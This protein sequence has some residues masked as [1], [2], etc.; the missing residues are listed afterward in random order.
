MTSMTEPP[1]TP[2]SISDFDFCA[3]FITL[4]T[5]SIVGHIGIVSFF[6]M[7]GPESTVISTS[8]PELERIFAMRS[9]EIFLVFLSTTMSRCLLSVIRGSIVLI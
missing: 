3:V 9:P 1:P 8:Y 4:L 2:I 5:S 6:L 7:I